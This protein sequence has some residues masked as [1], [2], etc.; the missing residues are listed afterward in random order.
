MPSPEEIQATLERL[1]EKGM[2]K[3]TSPGMYEPTELGRAAVII[4]DTTLTNN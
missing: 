2:L 3:E 4:G 1:V